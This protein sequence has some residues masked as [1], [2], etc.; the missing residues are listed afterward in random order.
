MSPIEAMLWVLF[1]VVAV[2]GLA[3]CTAAI[4]FLVETVRRFFQ[5][6]PMPLGIQRRP[7]G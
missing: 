5:A 6:D 2:I 1:A 3:I 4:L 7:P